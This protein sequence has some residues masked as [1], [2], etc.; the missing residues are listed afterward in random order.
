[1]LFAFGVPEASNN[2]FNS[3]LRFANASDLLVILHSD[4]V[5]RIEMI[6]QTLLQ[7]LS[8]YN[9]GRV[10]YTEIVLFDIGPRS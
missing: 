9:L 6:K 7:F 5:L 8:I 10:F 3:I 1:M 4:I 2:G